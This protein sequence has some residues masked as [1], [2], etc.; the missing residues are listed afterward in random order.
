M[1]LSSFSRPAL[2]EAKCPTGQTYSAGERKKRCA[3]PNQSQVLRASLFLLPVA[4]F[5]A[6]FS[7][8]LPEH[9]KAGALFTTYVANTFIKL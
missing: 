6:D 2:S 8:L 3:R 5:D 4:P 7:L 1:P 9:I